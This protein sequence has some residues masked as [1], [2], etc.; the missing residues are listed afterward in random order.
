MLKKLFKL[1]SIAGA[2]AFGAGND[3][4]HN[5]LFQLAKGNKAFA[6]AQGCTAK[7][8]FLASEPI[9]AVDRARDPARR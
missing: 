9:F 3:G 8:E 5:R 4:G 2:C 6:G 7:L 1:C